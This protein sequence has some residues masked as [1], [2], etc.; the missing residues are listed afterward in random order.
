MNG[1]VAFALGAFVFLVVSYGL[2]ALL[3]FV[4]AYWSFKRAGWSGWWFLTL[5]VPLVGLL[6][7]WWFAF[8]RWPN[9][10]GEPQG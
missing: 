7:L 2:A 4:P 1:E 10:H 5:P 3:L 8:G 9:E 6:V